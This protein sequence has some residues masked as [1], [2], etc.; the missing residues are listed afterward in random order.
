LIH[1]THIYT[2]AHFPGFVQTL[3]Y[4]VAGLN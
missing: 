3:R 1:L 4:N 2:T